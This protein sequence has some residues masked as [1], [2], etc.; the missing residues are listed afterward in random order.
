[1]ELAT[2]QF[3]YKNCKTDFEV[4]TKFCKRTRRSFLSAWLS[5]DF[6]SSS[7]TGT[8]TWI[9]INMKFLAPV[10]IVYVW[11]FCFCSLTKDHR[12]RPKYHKLLV[13]LNLPCN[14]SICC[15]TSNI[16]YSLLWS[17]VHTSALFP[18][19]T[20]FYPSL[21]G[22]GSRRGGLVQTVM[23]CT[24]SP[25]SSQ[26]SAITSSTLSSAGSQAENERNGGMAGENEW[27]DCERLI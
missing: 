9:Y 18:V 16:L 8:L 4:L 19:G 17:C 3:P 20:Q 13:S 2:G 22:V 27:C 26:C 6:Q 1:M 10:S 15:L 7:K 5:A 12:K 24:E 23:E 25:R 21:R 11:V 14:S